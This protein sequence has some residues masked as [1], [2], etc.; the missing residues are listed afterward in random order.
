[1]NLRKDNTAIIMIG[2]QN[3]YFHPDGSLYS[4]IESSSKQTLQ[5]TLNILDKVNGIT[6]FST[7]IVFTQNYQEIS[8]PI[9]ILQSIKEVGAFQKGSKGSKTVQELDQYSDRI[10]EVPGKVGLNAFYNTNLDNLLSIKK[11]ENVLIV[12]AVCAICIDSTAR[13]AHERGYNVAI[14][15]DAIS[16]RTDFEVSFYLEKIFPL[17]S[18]LITSEE[19]INQLGSD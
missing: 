18:S 14:V 15:S 10:I 16:G 8:E 5:N 9:G 7:P 11:I 4:V 13:S 17:Y 12:G 6:I 3:D 2:Y 1:M 19:I